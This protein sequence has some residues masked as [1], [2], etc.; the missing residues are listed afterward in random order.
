MTDAA[1]SAPADLRRAQRGWAL[2]DVAGS[3]FVTTMTAA[4]AGPYLLGLANAAAVGGRVDIGPLALAPGAFVAYTTTVS[5]LLQVLVLPLLGAV[6]DATGDKRRWL[7][8]LALT[9]SALTLVMALLPPTAWLAVGAAY[10]LANVCFGGALVPYNAMLADVSDLEERHRVSARGFAYGYAGGGL[11]L[12]LN[13]GL[14]QSAGALGLAG[15]TAARLD[16]ASVAVWW[17]GFTVVAMRLMAAALPPPVRRTAVPVALRRSLVELKG[18]LVELRRYPQAA[19]YLASFLLWNDGIQGVIGLAGV[20]VVHELFLAQGR[21][22][23]DGTPFVMVLVL[24]IQFC[25]IPGALVFARIADR[26]GA[27]AAILASLVL[28]SGIVLYAWTALS[29]TS[30]ALVLAVGIA[31]VLGGSQALARSLFVSMIPPGRENAWMGLYQ[32]AERGTSWIAPL[33]FGVALSATG[34]YRLGLAS[35]LV[36]FVGGGLLLLTV[37]ADRGV[38]QARV[39]PERRADAVQG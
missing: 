31:L 25:A 12:A 20:F 2:Y 17:A 22:E 3:A 1:Q 23:D 4:I 8:A 16:I 6:V 27:K 10:A 7:T 37:D 26:V 34:S 30:Q 35:L 33:L 9:G 11:L 29:T 21:P 19:K 14:L 5:V 38:A 36:L 24:V 39:G 15:S 28:W 32:T 18:A 13:L